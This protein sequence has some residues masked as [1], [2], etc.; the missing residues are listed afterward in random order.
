METQISKKKRIVF[1]LMAVFIICILLFTVFEISLRIF[2]PQ[3]DIF[4]YK[5]NVRGWI[6]PPNKVGYLIDD[7]REHNNK[8]EINSYG[9]WEREFDFEK[10]DGEYRIIILGDS[11]AVSLYIPME[12]RFDRIV[13]KKLNELN[14][15]LKY[16][17]YNLGVQGY[18]TDQEF[19][20]LI[21]DG[22][23][24]DPDLVILLFHTNDIRDNYINTS[25]INKLYF[26][27]DLELID[28]T[29][30]GAA[31]KIIEGIKSF[32]RNNFQSYKFF[33][34]R[35]NKVIELFRQSPSGG[36]EW[37]D[38]NPDNETLKAEEITHKI[39]KKMDKY[40]KSAG[41]ELLVV[42][43]DL[44][45]NEVRLGQTES[46]K[47]AAGRMKGREMDFDRALNGL[48]EFLD[49]EEISYLD[50]RGKFN[51]HYETNG[52][53]LTYNYDPHWNSEAHRIAADA[54]FEYL[55]NRTAE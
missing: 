31:Q 15:G 39:I 29:E 14:N 24:L 6:N 32:L 42:F 18:S 30:I 51:E 9:Y 55:K 2:Y 25:N 13:E 50:M 54:I 7:Q 5:D 40:S 53:S 16:T 21:N 4:Y 23:K 10:D 8:A 17:T 11:Q 46:S 22:V 3:G 37:Y 1:G 20:T 35:I 34:I 27:E 49:R 26:G 12:Q 44:V 47:Y 43:R 48:R 33:G 28:N 41:F 36:Y 52:S 45:P 19:F 38:K